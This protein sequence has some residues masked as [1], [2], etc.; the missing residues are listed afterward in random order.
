MNVK[1]GGEVY[2]GGEVRYTTS[3][4]KVA[5]TPV[6]KDLVWI[7]LQRLRRLWLEQQYQQRLQQHRQQ[8]DGDQGASAAA[9][10]PPYGD[11]LSA[12]SPEGYAKYTFEERLK[13]T[14]TYLMVWQR[15]TPLHRC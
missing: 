6:A 8:E 2:F 13:L 1:K 5:K 12:F 15:M 9:G 4:M 11:D 3:S 7:Q 10:S 14:P